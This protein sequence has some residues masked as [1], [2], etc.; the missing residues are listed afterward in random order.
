MLLL[1]ISWE[2]LTCDGSML[3]TH[4]HTHIYIRLCCRVSVDQCFAVI[5]SP[6]SQ[7]LEVKLLVIPCLIHHLLRVLEQTHVSDFSEKVDAESL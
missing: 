1:A 6:S 5:L 3:H 4:T 2:M 7:I